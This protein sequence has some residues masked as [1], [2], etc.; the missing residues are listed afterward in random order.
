MDDVEFLKNPDKWPHLVCP[1]KRGKESG[2]VVNE[3]VVR[4]LNIWKGWTPEEF[5]A[6]KTW[7]Y[8]S[9]EALVADGWIVD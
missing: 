8:P 1:V 4:E 3:P 6:A 2:I 9:F 7:E 5:D